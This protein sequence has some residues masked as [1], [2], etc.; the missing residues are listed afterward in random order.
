MIEGIKDRSITG[1]DPAKTD[2]DSPRRPQNGPESGDSRQKQG[3]NDAEGDPALPRDSLARLAVTL[4]GC[5]SVWSFGNGQVL[6]STA[7]RPLWRGRRPDSFPGL[8]AF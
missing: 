6:H 7:L 1:R 8:D 3:Q 4:S 2:L 5:F